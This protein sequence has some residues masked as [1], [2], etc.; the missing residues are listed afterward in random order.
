[1]RGE[2]PNFELREMKRFFYSFSCAIRGILLASNGRNFRIQFFVFIFVSVLGIFLNITKNEWLT[3]MLFSAL[4]LG[5]ESVNTAI[6]ELCDLY[7]IAPNPKIAR[8]KDTA[9]GAVLIVCFFAIVSG[10]LIFFKYLF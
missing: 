5:L 9:A 3:I 1:M 8:I 10:C 7:S 6:E 2:I 4:V